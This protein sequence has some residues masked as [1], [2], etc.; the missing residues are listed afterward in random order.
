MD[1]VGTRSE[2]G[3]NLAAEGF[4]F[5]PGIALDR[6]L[7]AEAISPAAWEAFASSWDAMP[8]DQYM[9]DGGRYRRRRFGVF[10][11]VPDQPIRRAVHQP[12]FQTREYNALNGGVERWFEPIP[13][14]IAN[15]DTFQALLGFTRS[16]FEERTGSIAWHIEAHQFRIEANPDGAGLPTPEGMH[17]DGVDFVLVLMVRRENIEQGT[18]TIHDLHGNDLGSFTL[19]AARDAALVD[20]QRVFHGVTPVIPLDPARAAFRDVLVLTYRRV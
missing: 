16:L 12:H 14:T 4:A 7:P 3:L 15:G 5:L 8:I 1:P 11:A 20:D 10:N 17:R 9:A 13:D 18:T 19:T 2:L 6:M